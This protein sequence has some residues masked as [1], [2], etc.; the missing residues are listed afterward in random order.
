MN[1]RGARVLLL[2]VGVAVVSLA[3][4][5][6][7]SEKRADVPADGAAA[8]I[9]VYGPQLQAL[10]WTVQRSEVQHNDVP[11][12]AAPGKRH[13]AVYVRPVGKKTPAEYIDG[14][15]TVSRVF[16]PDVFSRWPGLE[17]FDVCEEPSVEDD[18]AD[19][20]KPV[21]QILVTRK[22]AATVDWP[23]ARPVDVVKAGTGH[24]NTIVLYASP[25]LSS[26][27]EW[28]RAIAEAAS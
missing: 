14:L 4:A 7:S 1:V 3:A 6:T 13:L 9:K 28:S 17:S 16:L 26:T 8:M 23:N 10:G 12:V 25:E 24:P 11:G 21:T 20:P 19:E 5:C 27:R 18:P 15:A 22:Q 2:V